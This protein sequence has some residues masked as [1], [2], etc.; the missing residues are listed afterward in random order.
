M[1]A[2]LDYGIGN[3]AS[4]QKALVHVGADARLVSHHEDAADAEALVLPGVGAFGACVQALRVSGLDVAVYDAIA[5]NKP[6]LGVCVGM[7]MLFAE[8][9]ESPDARG[10]GILPGMVRRLHKRTVLPH[11]QWNQLIIGPAGHDMFPDEFDLPWMYFVHSYAVDCNDSLVAATCE[12][13]GR[14][15]AAI[16][17]ENIWAMQFHPEKSGSDGLDLLRRFVSRYENQR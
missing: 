17:H 14:V 8:S 7:Q 6:F 5:Q 2:V 10:L 15:I 3:L 9:E 12:Y 1:I 4:M 13:D 11:M 16:A